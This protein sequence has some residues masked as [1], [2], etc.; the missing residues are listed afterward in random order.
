MFGCSFFK[1]KILSQQRQ[2]FC[3]VFFFFQLFSV[4]IYPTGFLNEYGR[5]KT[6]KR[7]TVAKSYNSSLFH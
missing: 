4:F 5:L 1:L 2:D 6:E 7:I 3:F